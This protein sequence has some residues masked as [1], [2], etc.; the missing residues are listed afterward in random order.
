MSSPCSARFG[1]SPRDAADGNLSSF[2]QIRHL[3]HSLEGLGGGVILPVTTIT[4]DWQQVVIGQ[5]TC[6]RNVWG[7]RDLING[8][9]FTQAITCDPVSFPV[10]VAVA[11]DWPDPGDGRVLG[12]PALKAGWSPWTADGGQEF[13]TRI[14]DLKTYEMTFEVD[15]TGV[16]DTFNLAWDLWLTSTPFGGGTTIVTE[17]FISLHEPEAL[18]PTDSPVYRDPVSGYVGQI[19]STPLGTPE[20]PILFVGVV[21]RA[22]FLEGKLDLAPL[23]KQ[24]MR[25]REISPDAFVSGFEFGNEPFGGGVGG[26]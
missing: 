1:K 5:N 10:G 23:L 16:V 14:S 19:E 4:G 17:V 8:V 9:D 2:G 20:Q 26:W 18:G 13:V 24:L 25:M 12:F 15:L 11:W 22:D 6:V 3:R 21:A 7:R